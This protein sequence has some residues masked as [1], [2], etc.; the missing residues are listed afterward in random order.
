MTQALVLAN[1]SKRFGATQALDGVS[2]TFAA[3]EVHALVG[4]NGAGKSTLLGIVSGLVHPDPPSAMEIN[5]RAVDLGRWSPKAAQAAGVSL[6]PQEPAVIEPMTVAENIFL[7]REP[8]RGPVL[9]RNGMRRRAGELL[10]R[11]RCRFL[12]GRTRGAPERCPAP[13]AGDRQG[14]LHL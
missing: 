5:G 13:A 3:G 10:A 1:A 14:A 8:R 4:E 9:D 2:V 6:V 12:P 7:G 11:A